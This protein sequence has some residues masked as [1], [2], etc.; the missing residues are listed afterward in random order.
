MDRAP[1]H[2]SPPSGNF[3]VSPHRYLP[4]GRVQIWVGS[5][6]A[7]ISSLF[8]C[9][10][11]DCLQAP[12]APGECPLSLEREAPGLCYTLLEL[13]LIPGAHYQVRLVRRAGDGDTP[14]AAASLRACPSDLSRG[15]TAWYGTCFYRREDQQAL[16]GAFR[17]LPLDHRPDVT[18]LG[19]DQVYLDTAFSNLAPSPIAGFSA[20]N[21]RTFKKRGQEFIRRLLGSVFSNEYRKNW[22]GGL[23]EVL[24]TGASYF[25]AGD[26]EF[27]NDYPN[28]PGFLRSLRNPVLHDTWQRLARELFRAYQ[29]PDGVPS[30]QFDVG[31]EL[32]F[33]ALDTRLSR[34]AGRDSGMTDDRSL[35]DCKAWLAGLQSPGVLVLPAPLVT[36]WQFRRRWSLRAL[37]VKYGWGDHALTDT[38]QYAELVQALNDC[39][40]DVM[41]LA[42][43]VHFSRLAT[44]HLNGK[45]L[46]E[47]VS[48][49]LAC[50]PSATTGPK[51]PVTHFP[52][53]PVGNISTPVQYAEAGRLAR[54]FPCKATVH[55][56]VTV[57]FARAKNA[58][59][60]QVTC[61]DLSDRSAEASPAVDWQRTIELRR[62]GM[63][64]ASGVPAASPEEESA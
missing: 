24:R 21:F 4:G 32:S 23:R 62:R 60:A 44:M 39:A 35:A 57:R 55:N 20:M 2:A 29:Q 26:H 28:R 52:P 40:Q 42:G 59:E 12:E 49:P 45:S 54:D 27:W 38:G 13:D 47:V 25:L 41:I 56:F 6:S 64:V 33:F 36:P 19:G 31:N 7:D 48:S 16:R 18:F 15:F 50:L 3:I 5:F 51:Q 17:A 30:A 1:D 43:D 8:L 58:V 34:G 37:K 22:R 61:W 11:T 46:V 10:E 63:N 9:W 53:R 14:L